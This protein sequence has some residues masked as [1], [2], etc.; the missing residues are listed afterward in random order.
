MTAGV[1]R[2]RIL[3]FVDQATVSRDSAEPRLALN[4]VEFQM[5]KQGDS[6]VVDDILSF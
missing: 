1:D 4:R 6:W 5:V 3:L 2:A